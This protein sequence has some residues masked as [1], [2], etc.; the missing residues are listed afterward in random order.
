MNGRWAP[1][2]VFECLNGRVPPHE[3]V[4][5]DASFYSHENA[6]TAFDH[7]FFPRMRARARL[8]RRC[9]LTKTQRMDL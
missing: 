2:D 5:E 1:E 8:P 9:R 4:R 6:V 3:Y 7:T